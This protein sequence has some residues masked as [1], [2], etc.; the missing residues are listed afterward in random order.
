MQKEKIFLLFMLIS[1]STLI[2]AQ[3]FEGFETG[4]FSAYEWQLSGNANWFVTSSNPYEGGFCAQGGDINDSQTTSLEV[5]RDITDNG[6][7]SFYWKVNS[8]SGWDYLKFFLDGTLIQEISGTVSWTQVTTNVSAGLR[9]FKWQYYKDSSVTTGLDTGWID[10]IVFPP[11][12]TYDNDLAGMSITGNVITNAGNTE[13]YDITVKNVGS[14]PQNTY[15][16]KLF[17]DSGVELSSIDINQT[18]AP[19][20]SVIHNLVWNVPDDEPAGMVGLYGKVI[21]T[22]DENTANDETDVLNVEVFSQGVLEVTVGNGT[23]LNNRTPVRFQFMNSLTEM[24][25]FPDEMNNLT[26]TIIEVTFY[27]NFLHNWP[28]EDIAIWMGETNQMNLTDGWIPSTQLTPVFDGDV[29]FPVGENDIHVTLDTPYFY[30]GANLVMMVHRPM[31]SSQAGDDNFYHSETL[32]HE[33][34]TRYEAE[35]LAIV[36]DPANPPVGW[37]FEKFP[38]TTFSFFQGTMGDVEGYVYDDVGSPLSGAEIEIEE[39]NMISISNNDGFYQFGNVLTATYDF[40]A[41]KFGYSPQTITEEVLEDQTINIDF[42]LPPLGIVNVSGHV[43]GS[44]TPEIGLENALVTLTGF[45]NYEIYTDENGDFLISGVYTNITYDISISQDGYEVYYDEVDVAGVNLDLETITL[46]ELTFP[47]GNVQAVQNVTQTQVDLIWNSPGQGGGEFRYDDGEIDFQIGFGGPQNNGLIGA[48]HHN[49]AIIQEVQWLLTSTYGAHDDVRIVILGLYS[50]EPDVAQ[51]LHVSPML[52]NVDDEW[53]SYVLDEQIEAYEGFFVGIN[54]P[55]EYTSLAL[56]DGEGEPWIFEVGTHFTNENWMGGNDWSDIETLGTMFQRNMLLRAYGINLGNT[57][58][59]FGSSKM[60]YTLSTNVTTREFEAY[61]V[62]RFPEQYHNNPASWDLVGDAVTDTI[63]TDTS[64]S[65]LPLG[66][67]QFAIRSVHTNGIESL[68]AFSS[69]LGKT[70]TGTKPDQ[71]IS[72]S[73]ELFANYPNP[74]NPTTTIS[75]NVSNEQNERIELVI[76]NLKG[77][78]IK[79]FFPSL[80]HPE[81]FDKL[82]TGSVEGRGEMKYSVVWNGTDDNGHPVSSGIYFYKL[83]AGDFEKI[84][85]MLLMK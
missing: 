11:T 74:F 33:D 36:L 75:F 29:T 6:T 65:S 66:D 55:N 59:T 15:T 16:V 37:G 4:D 19:D 48:V 46:N 73:T 62:Y 13:N 1:I 10:N 72:T 42:N 58:L 26:G 18:I 60:E 68:P 35:D 69:I 5:T 84:R 30:E 61:N 83:K 47:P 52:D 39:L 82:R 8:E 2:L 64:W 32:E 22:G 31:G 70:M 79:T 77:Q 25:Y 28:N 57:D 51:I 45:E 44:D 9:T 54:T 27:S 80:C 71:I 76:Y 63:F 34:R 14:N 53:N 43:V 67:Y 78:R 7:I 38:N 21:L 12:I 20:E 40:T 17:K 3:D 50:G 41:S 49:I 23:E 56:D 85:K 81:P 24:L